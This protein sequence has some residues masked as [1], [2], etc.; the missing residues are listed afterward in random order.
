MDRRPESEAPGGTFV[1]HPLYRGRSTV[2]VF[3]KIRAELARDQRAYALAMEGADEHEQD[4][5]A[6]AVK[7]DRK[8]GP[9]DLDWATA[10]P[11]EVAQRVVAFEQARD[12]A[13]E[14]FPYRSYRDRITQAQPAVR[15][16]ATFPAMR[17]PMLRLVVAAVAILLVLALLA[18]LA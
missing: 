15:E 5:L 17:G 6:A 4:T 13:Q 16:G 18:W 3:A 1:W 7:L 8:W 9:F 11:A 10:D 12:D 14:L 2:G